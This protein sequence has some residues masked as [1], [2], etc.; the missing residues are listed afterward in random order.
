[1]TSTFRSTD[2]IKISKLENC[3]V[4][5]NKKNQQNGLYAKAAFKAGDSIVAF[6][7]SKIVETPNYLTIQISENQHIHI[8]PE[9]L[10]FVNHSCEPNVLFNTTTMQLE[11]VNDIE[12][13]DELCFFYPA[14]EWRIAQ[15][16]ICNCGKPNCVGL[17]QG[18]ADTPIEVLNTYKLT[19]F[20]RQMMVK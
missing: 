10:Q 3:E 20:I 15:Q 13:G 2:F 17:V 1:M 9:Y 11:C 8:L 19:D 16:F 7:A 12:V 6:T 4:R 14:T 18:A 5:L